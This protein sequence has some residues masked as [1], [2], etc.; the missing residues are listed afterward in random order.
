MHSMMQLC[1]LRF[2]CSFACQEANGIDRLLQFLASFLAAAPVQEA[3]ISSIFTGL[4]EEVLQLTKLIDDPGRTRAMQL[5]KAVLS[6]LA[7][8]QVN[9]QHQHHYMA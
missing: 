5:V 8:K 6:A 2:S 3:H 4:V 9:H 1:H 7:D